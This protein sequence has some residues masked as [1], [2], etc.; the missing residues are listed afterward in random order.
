MFNVQILF[1]EFFYFLQS[2]EPL[3]YCD[4]T[5]KICDEFSTDQKV[6]CNGSCMVVNQGQRLSKEGS[7]KK[8]VTAEM[9]AKRAG[10]TELWR[11][12]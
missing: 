9:H 4:D 1:W 5:I 8:P 2:V 11:S 7:Q 10:V 3:F 6:V 12:D